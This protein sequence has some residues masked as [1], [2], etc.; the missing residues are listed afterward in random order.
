M[1]SKLYI[2]LQNSTLQY[3]TFPKLYNIL[4]HKQTLQQQLYTSVHI[5]PNLYKI[6]VNK[7]YTTF[8]HV[9]TILLNSSKTLSTIVYNIAPHSSQLYTQLYNTLQTQTRQHSTQL[10][11]N[12]TT[13][14][15]HPRFFT[16]KVQNTNTKTLSHVCTPL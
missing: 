14:Y 7:S 12:S 3:N 13:P 8:T 15:K 16:Q 1:F 10:Y 9:Y 6:L 11:T 5:S 2:I 4:Q